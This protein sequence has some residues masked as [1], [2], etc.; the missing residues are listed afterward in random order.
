MN[1]MSQSTS[2]T[3][4]LQMAMRRMVAIARAI[5]NELQRLNN[6]RIDAVTLASMPHSDRTRI[7]KAALREH[8]QSPNRCC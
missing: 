2:L 8:H 3:N 6:A 4:Q 1:E 7:V 5:T